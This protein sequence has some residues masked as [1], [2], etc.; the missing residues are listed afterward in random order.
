MTGVIFIV[1][2]FVLLAYT[3][4]PLLKA[5]Q[6]LTVDG[7]ETARRRAAL[8]QEKLNNLQAI[9]DIDFERT[10]DK[11]SEADHRE[12][13]ELYTRQAAAAMKA[14]DKLARADEATTDAH[15]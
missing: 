1:L 13:K 2:A 11:V 14:L 8:E 3:C 10:I 12:L 4:A 6:P 7:E 9:R 15:S 5:P